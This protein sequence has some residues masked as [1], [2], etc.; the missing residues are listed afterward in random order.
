MPVGFCPTGMV[1]VGGRDPMAGM[2]ADAGV[3]VMV[4]AS[5][6]QLAGT[7]RY[8]SRRPAVAR[9]GCV[10]IMERITPRGWDCARSE[11]DARRRDRQGLVRRT[12]DIP[13]RITFS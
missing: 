4:S 3:A 12:P 1:A 6:P 2:L 8:L 9:P 5:A 7:V 13:P 10:L 11:P